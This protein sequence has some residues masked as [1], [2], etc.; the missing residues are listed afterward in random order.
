MRNTFIAIAA[1]LFCLA[2]AGCSVAV[3]PY[4][5][6]PPPVM[7]GPVLPPPPPPIIYGPVPPPVFFGP[8]IFFGGFEHH[9]WRRCW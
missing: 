1:I 5:P 2:L 8:P 7:Y 9:C 6:V 4:L 3:D